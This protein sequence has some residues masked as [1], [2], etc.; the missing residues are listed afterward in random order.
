MSIRFHGLFRIGAAI[1]CVSLAACGAPPQAHNSDGTD[2]APTGSP[3][4]PAAP[5]VSSTPI[6]HPEPLKLSDIGRNVA[7]YRECKLSLEPDRRLEALQLLER[8]AP[9]LMQPVLVLLVDENSNNHTKAL[10]QLA[11]LGPAAIPT[12]PVVFWHSERALAA[13]PQSIETAHILGGLRVFVAA[14]PEQ[15]AVLEYV[16]QHTRWQISAGLNANEVERWQAAA[17][18]KKVREESLQLLCGLAEKEPSHRAAVATRLRQ[19]FDDPDLRLLAVQRLPACRTAATPLL[20]DLDALKFDANSEMRQ[21]SAES[22]E[23]V[24]R[25]DKYVARLAELGIH[26]AEAPRDLYDR[27][28][29]SLCFPEKF[30]YPAQIDFHVD[31]IDILRGICQIRHDNAEL[32][33]ATH[34]AASRALA[35][36]TRVARTQREELQSALL[37]VL[38]APEPEC[39][40]EVSKGLAR[41]PESALPAL[42]SLAA[43]A[44]DARQKAA[45]Q[46][47]QEI[48]GDILGTIRNEGTYDG[49]LLRALV[50]S[51]PPSAATIE[52]L[53]E[54]ADCKHMPEAD[55]SIA[56]DCLAG[57]GKP[58][59]IV[60]PKLWGQYRPILG[61]TADR[62]DDCLGRTRVAR[63]AAFKRLGLAS[64]GDWEFWASLIAHPELATAEM[65]DWD[66][67]YQAFQFLWR[68]ENEGA[69][70]GRLDTA[71]PAIRLAFVRTATEGLARES[72]GDK[73][74]NA[75][76]YGIQEPQAVA[77]HLAKHFGPDARDVVPILADLIELF[78][79]NKYAGDGP[80]ERWVEALMYIGPAG[81]ERSLEALASLAASD[82]R[83]T[84]RSVSYSNPLA[85]KRRQEIHAKVAEAQAVVRGE[86]PVP[87][88]SPS[89]TPKSP[90]SRDT[91]KR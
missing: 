17:A 8:V 66:L 85:Q 81:G 50:T 18:Q 37:D 52:M 31:C 53:A 63:Q 23:S 33:A 56:L 75:K 54:L 74:P 30:G 61:R 55:I 21:A 38:A 48:E 90:A 67:R 15:P 69:G 36:G 47:L 3:V 78:A 83:L 70:T 11:E 49:E 24:R 87:R 10:E 68:A 73:D 32:Q 41:I 2:G 88:S 13:S 29:N 28:L 91:G 76:R 77:L 58:S 45:Q 79:A 64:D 4:T 51:F 40:R 25:L 82:M 65:A 19:L 86:K 5:K 57:L 14:A 9:N 16:L 22:A 12:F 59:L 44:T 80:V 26:E 46:C 42:R 6:K 62:E 89:P 39:V 72:A 35:D 27:V 43:T 84:G 7:G 1:A 60:A 34:V 71:S 20:T